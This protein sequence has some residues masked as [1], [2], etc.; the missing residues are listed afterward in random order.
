MPSKSL[1]D[2]AQSELRLT[3]HWVDDVIESEHAKRLSNICT[4]YDVAKP[5]DVV[6]LLFDAEV[7]YDEVQINRSESVVVIAECG[8]PVHHLYV[9]LPEDVTRK[10]SDDILRLKPFYA[11]HNIIDENPYNLGR[12]LYDSSDVD[13]QTITVTSSGV[14]FEY[15]DYMSHKLLHNC[16]SMHPTQQVLD[17]CFFMVANRPA[18]SHDAIARMKS[19]NAAAS[20]FVALNKIQDPSRTSLMSVALPKYEL[21]P[22]KDDSNTRHAS[23]YTDMFSSIAQSAI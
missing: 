3:C 11:F 23:Y 1:S 13:K 8:R 4:P 19:L 7:R 14:C 10:M 9:D 21:S 5:G 15:V 20:L 6:A 22:P 2:I 12:T 18:T 17:T 16:K